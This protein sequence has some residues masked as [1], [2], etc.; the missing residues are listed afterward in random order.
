VHIYC[1][2]LLS[3]HL[4]L[5]FF[6]L[7]PS[8]HTS[9][10]LHNIQLFPYFPSFQFSRIP[11]TLSIVNHIQFFF[12]YSPII[13]FF[14]PLKRHCRMADQSSFSSFPLTRDIILI[15]TQWLHVITS[16]HFRFDCC[17]CWSAEQIKPKQN[18]VF[19]RTFCGCVAALQ[20]VKKQ[21][22]IEQRVTHM[23]G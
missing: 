14:S 10:N 9:Q 2:G 20:F 15:I 4:L 1:A 3:V 22:K 12:S 8:V 19:Q 13:I 18:S 7:L 6:T 17:C 23:H 11:Y 5:L 21:N 16:L